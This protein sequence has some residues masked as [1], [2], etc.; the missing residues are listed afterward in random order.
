MSICEE[1]NYHVNPVV[2]CLSPPLIMI[3]SSHLW[4]VFESEWIFKSIYY[5]YQH[6]SSND[7]SQLTLS[8]ILLFSSLS[9]INSKHIENRFSTDQTLRETRE[10]E[11]KPRLIFQLHKK[12]NRDETDWQ[13]YIS[14]CRSLASIVFVLFILCRWREKE[15]GIDKIE[16][17][18]SFFLMMKKTKGKESFC[19]IDVE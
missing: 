16:N 8:M 15:K 5:R 7:T 17:I 11:E 4:F 13:Q 12:K 18:E 3:F 10:R 6:G 19:S 14:S 1:W 2:Q 9:Q